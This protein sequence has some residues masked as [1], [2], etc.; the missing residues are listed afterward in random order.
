MRDKAK[1]DKTTLGYLDRVEVAFPP[2]D[3]AVVGEPA[4][5]IVPNGSPETRINDG[6]GARIKRATHKV[7]VYC[8][9]YVA[10]HDD[11]HVI[12]GDGRH[13]GIVKFVEDAID[14]FSGNLLSLSGLEAQHAP[15]IEAGDNTYRL[16]ETEDDKWM[17][18][19]ALEYEAQTKPYVR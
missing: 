14:F 11:A 2:L 15:D 9:L 17:V 8:V 13:V 3:H 7:N 5:F 10:S 6:G 18:F 12:L 4:L 16:A 1:Q 19:V